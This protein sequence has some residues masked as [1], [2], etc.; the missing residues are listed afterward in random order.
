[1][2]DGAEFKLGQV[3][4]IKPENITVTLTP[5]TP[6]TVELGK[7]ITLTPSTTPSLAGTTY[8]YVYDPTTGS[9]RYLTP[10]VASGTGVLTLTGK[11]VTTTD[12]KVKA[13]ASF[14]IEGNAGTSTKDSDEVAVKVTSP[15][16]TLSDV[17]VNEGLS[18][19]LTQATGN[20]YVSVSNITTTAGSYISIAKSSTPALA[21]DITITG[22][23][24]TKL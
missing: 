2:D 8:S 12:V 14:A 22:S 1:M 9:T 18:V 21:K 5:S 16:L 24:A 3:Y 20:G 4:I 11:E 10:S 19:P 7:S 15:T 13:R 23:N 6:Q 17:Y